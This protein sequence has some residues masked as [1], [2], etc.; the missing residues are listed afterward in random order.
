MT[1]KQRDFLLALEAE[2]KKLQIKTAIDEMLDEDWKDHWQNYVPEYASEC[3]ARTK[4][5]IRNQRNK[6]K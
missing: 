5:Q 3:I 1:P 6:N 4:V 2:A